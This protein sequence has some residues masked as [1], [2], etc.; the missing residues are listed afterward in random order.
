VLIKAGASGGCSQGGIFGF[1]DPR[2]TGSPA[3]KSTHRAGTGNAGRCQSIAAR[4]HLTRKIPKPQL[5]S[6]D[7]RA[8][9]TQRGTA[10]FVDFAGDEMTFL[11]EMVLDLSMH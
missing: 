2:T 3:L 1:D 10:L 4:R 5:R 11:V 9:F 6:R 7:E 8:P